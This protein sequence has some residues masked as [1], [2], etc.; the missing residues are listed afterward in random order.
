MG[1]YRT[2]LS[3]SAKRVGNCACMGLDPQW[4]VLP[5]RSG[6]IREDVTTFFTELFEAMEQQ[7]LSSPAAFK[8]NIGYYSALDNPREGQFEGSLALADLLR[9]VACEVFRNPCDTRFEAGRYRQIE[10]Q[11][12]PR[13]LRHLEMRCGYHKWLHGHR[14]GGSVR[15]HPRRFERHLCAQ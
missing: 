3:E 4:D 15:L 6:H 14:F 7:S 13:G 8:P 1:G 12:C 10:R 11:L 9:P 5:Y 2:V